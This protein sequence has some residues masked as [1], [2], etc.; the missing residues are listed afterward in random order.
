LL[1]RAA[2]FPRRGAGVPDDLALSLPQ[3]PDEHRPERPILLAVDQEFGEGPRLRVPPEL[4]D[5][6]GA[7]EVGE[8]EDVEQFSPGSWA[9]GVEA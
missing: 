5:P 3:H 1:T 7:V 6:V 4:S 2:I 8:H 9:E